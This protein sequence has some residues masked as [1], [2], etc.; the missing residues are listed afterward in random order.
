MKTLLIVDDNREFLRLLASILKKQFQIYEAMGV[1]DALKVLETVT[2]D[3]ICS[4]YSMKD[5]TGPEL[6][7]T[8]RLED[9]HLPFLLMSDFDDNHIINEAHNYGASF[10]CKTDY[11][12]ITKIKAL[13]NLE[14]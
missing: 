5:G 6:L 12:L 14:L 8:L 7:K 3:A 13:V 2:V 11:D 1:N 9:I 10:C 4:D